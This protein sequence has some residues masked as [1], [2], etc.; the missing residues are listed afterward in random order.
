MRT[1]SIAN[2]KSTS[3]PMGS[4]FSYNSH[5]QEDEGRNQIIPYPEVLEVEPLRTEKP[6]VREEIHSPPK[7][8]TPS[9]PTSVAPSTSK[10]QNPL[11]LPIVQRTRSGRLRTLFPF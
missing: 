9:A 7:T 2:K 5:E 1:K 11:F 3:S 10:V 8:Q 4:D 6:L